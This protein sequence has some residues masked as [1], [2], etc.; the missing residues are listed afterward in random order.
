[1]LIGLGGQINMEITEEKIE[2]NGQ[3]VTL[4]CLVYERRVEFTAFITLAETPFYLVFKPWH[5]VNNLHDAKQAEI[6]LERKKIINDLEILTKP[7]WE[8]T[9]RVWPNTWVFKI[10]GS[11]HALAKFELWEK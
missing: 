6:S 7:L 2:M 3:T 5:F 11:P 1:M 10:N 8:N 9:L 4:C